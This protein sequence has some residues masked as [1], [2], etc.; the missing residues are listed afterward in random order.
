MFLEFLDTT[1]F[2]VVDGRS[3]HAERTRCLFVTQ[4][5]ADDQVD[6]GSLVFVEALH[7]RSK[8]SGANESLL[9]FT[10]WNLG[11]WSLIRVSR[12]L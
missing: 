10:R 2:P 12:T 9:N 5:P 4:S 3:V 7:G 1:M 11:F 6:G 8:I